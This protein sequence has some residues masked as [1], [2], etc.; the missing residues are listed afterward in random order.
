MEP[1]VETRAHGYVVIHGHFY[2]PPR[3]N[4]WI[5]EIELEESAQPFPNWN[6]RITN[7]C[8]TP[9]G[10]AR[11]NDEQVRILDIVNNYSYI[12]FNFGPTLLRWLEVYAP[13]V[14]GRILEADRES[15]ARLGFG[16]AMA[17]AYNH[18]ILP[19]AN[20]RDRETEIVWGLEDFAY[21]FGRPAEAMWLPETAVNY[22]TLAALQAHGMK[23]V[24]LAPQQARRIRPL[25][26]GGWEEPGGA[27]LDTTQ[28]YRCYIQD[29]AG[30][31]HPHRYIDIFFYNGT[32]AGEMSFGDL[33][34][35][36]AKLV[37]RMGRDYAP[38]TPRPQILTVATD[39]E[40]FGHHKK[41]AEL[42]LAYALTELF[43]QR[44]LTV[45]NYRAFLEL[46]PPRWE[47]ELASG[48][49][50]EG[51]AWSCAH[52][53]GRWQRD[54]GCHTGGQPGWNQ[55]WRAPL[56]EAFDHLNDRLAEI[57]ES[58]GER[59]LRDPWAARNDYI[60]VI[61][62]R[63]PERVEE[64]F[65]QHGAAELDQA[66]RINVL[67]LLEMQR[68]ALLMYTSCGWFF[69][70][71]AGLET[72][73]VIKYAA[74]ALQLGQRFTGEDLET[75]FLEILEKARSNL[76]EEGSGRDIYLKR[77]LPTV[78]T[79]PKLV[80]QF[81]ICLLQHRGRECPARIYHYAPQL[82]DY[83][84][85]RHGG[86]QLALGQVR[87]TSG[88]TG[89]AR[90]LCFATLFMG[91]YLYRT[92]VKDDLG[93]REFDELQ[94]ALVKA[95]VEAPEDVVNRMA[96]I[97]GGRFYTVR[98]M[99]RQEKREIFRHLLEQSQEEARQQL[100]HLFEG[101]RSLLLTMA[102]EG[103]QLP[104]L[105]SLA[106]ELALGRALA[107]QISQ[108]REDPRGWQGQEDLRALITEAKGLGLHLRHAMATG[109]VETMLQELLGWLTEDFSLDNAKLLQE[110]L[111]V[112]VQLPLD[113]D[114]FE[115]Q[116]R[117]FALMEERFTRLG[118]QSRRGGGQ[119]RAL[120]EV[121]VRTAGLLGF[122]PGQ[123]VK[124]M[125]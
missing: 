63:S 53:V 15:R 123:Y 44:G 103:L 78:V 9:N 107:G 71:L 30:K 47:V 20:A 18:V 64:F 2:Q 25:G 114:R 66:G 46:H 41:F 26:G 89:E 67:K 94:Q 99:F 60:R 70:D 21:R 55:S 58:T 105:A 24:I 19:L 91:S 125:E 106:A 72:Q 92:Q 81:S 13:Q 104:P 124:E 50:G 17:Q 113:F 3:E 115:A 28:P 120:A 79:F 36:S 62:D 112:S 61:L 45:T 52:G 48:P 86:L 38:E 8:Y 110:F 118:A 97:F 77:V 100:E 74:R 16:N 76:K 73:Q 88:I 12:S 84:E 56:R 121:L 87:L 102:Q 23:Y 43:P 42:A 5:E 101:T 83:R 69:S 6:A 1:R 51:T 90:T 33:L 109:Q 98:D 7:E 65:D 85:E 34:S 22:P 49:G 119:A 14:H 117:F 37:D 108:W 68:H 122:N 111:G 32:V 93:G 95:L 59:F 57:F 116:N 35:A 39:G 4:P 75:P 31:K 27:G 40:T 82:W 29:E 10:W 54:C 11:I 80:N 96:Q